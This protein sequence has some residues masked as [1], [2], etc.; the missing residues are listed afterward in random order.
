MTTHQTTAAEPSLRQMELTEFIGQGH[1]RRSVLVV[2]R[3]RVRQHE[4]HGRN[5]TRPALRL[6]RTS[7][8]ASRNCASGNAACTSGFSARKV[9]LRLAL[10]GMML[11]ELPAC[12]EQTVMRPDSIGS[13]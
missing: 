1:V 3:P 2:E 8:I 11:C 5:T 10:A 12:N 7:A 6:S 13:T 9:P 4:D